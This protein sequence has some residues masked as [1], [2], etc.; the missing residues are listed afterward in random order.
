[1]AFATM[2][3]PSQDLSPSEFAEHVFNSEGKIKTFWESEFPNM[4]LAV[5]RRCVLAELTAKFL[6]RNDLKKMSFHGPDD[7]D[8]DWLFTLYLK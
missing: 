2:Q 6:N 1:M 3:R 7:L 8:D 5:W 4:S